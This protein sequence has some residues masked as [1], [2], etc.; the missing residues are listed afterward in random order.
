[1]SAAINILYST[2]PGTP[3]VNI[4]LQILPERKFFIPF[5]D[6]NFLLVPHR[7][8]VGGVPHDDGKS[9]L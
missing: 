3:G 4:S 8:G 7:G 1:M 5:H 2:T 6:K 9:V